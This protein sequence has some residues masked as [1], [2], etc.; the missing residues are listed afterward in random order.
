[1]RE[2]SV[3]GNRA[4]LNSRATA[5]DAV[6]LNFQKLWQRFCRTSNGTHKAQLGEIMREHTVDIVGVGRRQRFLRLHNF[7][8][9]TDSRIKPL[10]C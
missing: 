8:I 10:A 7:K 4:L 2:G 3:S 5:P 1:M 9:V 6:L